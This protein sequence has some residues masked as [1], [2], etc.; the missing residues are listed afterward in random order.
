MTEYREKK[1][2]KGNKL[3]KELTRQLMRKFCIRLAIYVVCIIMLFVIGY[4]ICAGQV[5]YGWEPLYPLVH[6]VHEHW[7]GCFMVCVVAGFAICTVSSFKNIVWILEYILGAVNRIYEE[8][9]ELIELPDELHEVEKELNHVSIN[10]KRSKQKAR[11]AEKRKNDMIVYMAHD[12]KTPLTSVIG[13]LSLLHD[14][15]EISEELKSRYIG[16]ALKKSERLEELINEFFEITRFNLSAAPLNLST[17]NLT[18]MLEQIAYEFIPL[19]QEKKLTYQLHLEK[20]ITVVCD[21]EKMERVFDNLL[22]NVVNY[23]YEGTE[24]NLYARTEYTGTKESGDREQIVN[25]RFVNHGKTIPEEKREQIFE[26]FFR[27]ETAR[28]SKTGGAGLG[29]AIAREI[30]EQ[31]G[32]SL[33]CES[34]DETITFELK[35]KK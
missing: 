23:S 9:E 28:G 24:M 8:K 5:W 27:M 31:H 35:L 4:E 30:V 2:E 19:F 34:E 25:L 3:R 10:V 33:I 16:I 14:E 29:L 22:K 12:L 21:V 13:Y 1:Y 11:E 15:A 32:G 17:V 6:F 7:F 26:Q 18:R 20:D